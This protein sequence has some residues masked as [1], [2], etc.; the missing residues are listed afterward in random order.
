MST[1]SDAQRNKHLFNFYQV[2]LVVI[3]ILMFVFFSTQIECGI[4][5]HI[6]FLSYD[7]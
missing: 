2:L 4:S 6:L 1:R 7:E 3:I 5:V